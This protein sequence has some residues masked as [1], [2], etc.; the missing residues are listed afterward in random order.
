VTFD[1]AQLNALSAS[2]WGQIANTAFISGLPAAVVGQLSAA[3]LQAISTSAIRGL[4]FSAL[5]ATQAGELTAAQLKALQTNQI[6]ALS[7]A[8]VTAICVA[9]PPGFWAAIPSLWL[10]SLSS[11]AISGL[12]PS[13]F[14]QIP[15]GAINMLSSTFVSEL[16]AAVVAGLTSAQIA[17]LNFSALGG[18]DVADLTAAQIGEFSLSQLIQLTSNQLPALD[19]AQVAAIN[20]ANPTFWKTDNLALISPNA[21]AGLGIS[22]LLALTGGT[23][24]GLTAAQLS[25][26]TTALP[27]FWSSVPASWVNKLSTSALAGFPGSALQELPLATVALLTSTTFGALPTTDWADL[28]PQQIAVLTPTQFGNDFTNDPGYIANIAYPWALNVA[29]IAELTFQVMIHMP[30]SDFSELD[31]IWL[32]DLPANA[33]KELNPAQIQAIL[34]QY[35][36][37][38]S[39]AIIGSLQPGEVSALTPAQVEAFLPADFEAL[40][41]TAS[42]LPNA[43]LA[44]LTASQLAGVNV[45]GIFSNSQISSSTALQ[46][47]VVQSWTTSQIESVGIP[48]LTESEIQ[49]LTPTQIYDLKPQDIENFSANQLLEMNAQ[50]LATIYDFLSYDPTTESDIQ[51][52]IATPSA[53]VGLASNWSSSSYGDGTL[54]YSSIWPDLTDQQVAAL[55]NA[56]DIA[57]NLGGATP[58]AKNTFTDLQ[59]LTDTA[60]AALGQGSDA[61]STLDAL[62]AE[63]YALST[64]LTT[65]ELDSIAPSVWQAALNA[66]SAAAVAYFKSNATQSAWYVY[67]QGQSNPNW[68]SSY[69]SPLNTLSVAQL[70]VLSA[71]EVQSLSVGTLYSLSTAQYAAIYPNLTAAQVE[72][73]LFEEVGGLPAAA[74]ASFFNSGALTGDIQTLLNPGETEGQEFSGAFT[75]ADQIAAQSFINIYDQNYGEISANPDEFKEFTS[76]YSLLETRSNTLIADSTVAAQITADVDSILNDFTLYND[77]LTPAATPSDGLSNVTNYVEGIANSLNGAEGGIAALE[78]DI[79]GLSAIEAN[80]AGLVLDNTTEATPSSALLQWALDGSPDAVTPAGKGNLTYA[81][82]TGLTFQQALEQVEDTLF[83]NADTFVKNAQTGIANVVASQTAAQQEQ[84]ISDVLDV[85]G[86][87]ISFGGNIGGTLNDFSSTFGA[88]AVTGL[89]SAGFANRLSATGSVIDYLVATGET[90]GKDFDSPSDPAGTYSSLSS[91]GGYVGAVVNNLTS[92]LTSGDATATSAVNEANAFANDYN[93]LVTTIDKNLSQNTTTLGAQ[94]LSTSALYDAVENPSGYEDVFWTNPSSAATLESTAAYLPT[95]DPMTY[96]DS[97][98]ISH[99]ANLNLSSIFGSIGADLNDGYVGNFGL[100]AGV[101]V[102]DSHATYEYNGT[103]AYWDMYAPGPQLPGFASTEVQMRIQISAATG[104]PQSNPSAFNSNVWN[105]VGVNLVGYNPL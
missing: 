35:F 36:P 59:L 37:Y 101:E 5:S 102:A 94:T 17:A 96:T 3:S 30:A 70:A 84:L 24:S 4:S 20:A 43:D 25:A 16:P 23:Q 42:A 79:T 52:I 33:L 88:S 85:A 83:T 28:T 19:L 105:V 11:A 9:N 45:A 73:L 100:P 67:E 46:T 44:G 31:A 69:S 87:I 29:V 18:L 50:Q 75:T 62:I 41:G 12:T 51:A 76:F 21:I 58:D 13:A 1:A 78:S 32:N 6:N 80:V 39:S 68:L 63:S 91:A 54:G 38:L 26:I 82:T 103:F 74:Q 66:G 34:P 90:L 53:I 14:A 92:L 15:T 93:T 49:D 57:N 95:D 65:G 47:A 89:A 56:G 86:A 61:T 77:A 48:N 99:V 60:F 71:T 81:G 98:G 7:A 8:Q 55:T 72:G 64:P 10:P 27:G 40:S 22:G 104:S 2:A 97:Q